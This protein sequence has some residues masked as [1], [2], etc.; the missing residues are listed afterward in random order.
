MNILTTPPASLLSA[1]PAKAPAKPDK[2]RHFAVLADDGNARIR[3]LSTYETNAKGE[4]V[5]DI[6]RVLITTYD[7]ADIVSISVGADH[8]LNARING[9]DYKLPLTANNDAHSLR[10]KTAGGNDRINVD[11]QINIEMHIHG[12]DGDDFIVANGR[13]GSVTGDTGNDY[14]RLGAGHVV[15]FGGDGDDIMIAGAG[16]AVISGGKGNDKLYASYPAQKTDLRQVYLNGDQGNDELY[17]GTGR[18][19]LNGGLGD[20]KLVGYRQTT[21]YTGAGQDSVHS[22]DTQDRIYAKKNR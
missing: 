3:S 5:L 12:G 14:I 18:S 17:A 20:D 11:E 4:Q 2:T 9:K 15:A 1:P 10:I 7:Q 8:Q 13:V 16:N 6:C 22:Y 19:I 21:I